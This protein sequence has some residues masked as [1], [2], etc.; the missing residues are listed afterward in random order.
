MREGDY[1]TRRYFGY[2][3]KEAMQR[4]RTEFPLRK[5]RTKKG[6]VTP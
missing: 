4:F 2:T 6:Q 3:K 1:V 5:K